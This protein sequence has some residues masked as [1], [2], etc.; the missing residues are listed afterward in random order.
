MKLVLFN[1]LTEENKVTAIENLITHSTPNQDY[2]FMIFLS[3]LTAVFGILLG[4]ITVVIGSMLIAP[5][6]SPILSLSLGII[7]SDPNL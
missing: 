7:I 3:I 6:L 5:L 4:S 2:F 1:N